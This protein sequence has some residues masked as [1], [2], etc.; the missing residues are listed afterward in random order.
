MNGA[1]TRAKVSV[2]PPGAELMMRVTVLPSNEGAP[3]AS[4]VEDPI[5]QANRTTAGRCMVHLASAA[6]LIDPRGF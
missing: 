5:R 6:I 2:P 1:S 3:C 4:A